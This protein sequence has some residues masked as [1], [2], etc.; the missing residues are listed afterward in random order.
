MKVLFFFVSVIWDG[1]R[2]RHGSVDLSFLLTCSSESCRKNTD[3]YIFSLIRDRQILRYHWGT[4]APFLTVA[5][6]H[7]VVFAEA[8]WYK[9]RCYRPKYD[10]PYN[11]HIMD[12]PQDWIHKCWSSFLAS[13]ALWHQWKSHIFSSPCGIPACLLTGWLKLCHHNAEPEACCFLWPGELWP[14]H[15]LPQLQWSREKEDKV[16]LWGVHPNLGP[17]SMTRHLP[18]HSVS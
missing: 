18:W 1:E 11:V 15:P 7:P 17:S 8:L 6:Q 14:P 9:H 13:D 12:Y 3:V 5:I 16:C 4:T 2:K 10:Q